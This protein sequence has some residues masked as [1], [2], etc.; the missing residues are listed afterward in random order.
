MLSLEMV[1]LLPLLVVLASL[2]LE[3]AGLTRDVL[4]V[5][6]AAR[7]GARAAATSSGTAIPERAAGDA[8]PELD[9]LEVVVRPADRR[10]G[11]LVTVEVTTQRRIGPTTHQIH[12]ST[13]ARV[14][15]GVGTDTRLGPPTEVGS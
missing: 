10:D 3:L 15:P 9:D 7:A 4:V 2:L 11:D 12:A 1:L 13:V 14:E 5:H 8:A 6:E